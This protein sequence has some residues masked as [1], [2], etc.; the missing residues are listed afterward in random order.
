M[1]ILYINHLFIQSSSVQLAA[2]VPLLPL[3]QSHPRRQLFQVKVLIELHAPQ[4]T[5][6][7]VCEQLLGENF[8]PNSLW[9]MSMRACSLY[10]LHGVF[11][12][13]GR[14]SMQIF[15]FYADYSNAE[16]QFDRIWSLIHTESTTLTYFQISYT[17]PKIAP[18]CRSLHTTFS[19]ST[20]IDRRC[21][22]WL[23]RM[24][25][26]RLQTSLLTS[27]SRAGNHYSLRG[28]QEKAIQYFRR[29]TELDQTYLS[30]WTL[31]GHE[32]VEVKNSHAAIESY[33]RAIG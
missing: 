32:Y 16:V 8:F 6:L 7:A 1:P 30:A 3:D 2:I 17:L 12:P 4:D 31:M 18:S 14:P 22:V 13:L 9:I 26:L 21:V 15:I 20:R 19:L 27:L 11:R 29:A 10:H 5:E 33:R 28:E 25:L 24:T 23:V